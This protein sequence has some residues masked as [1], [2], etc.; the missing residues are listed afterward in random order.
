MFAMIMIDMIAYFTDNYIGLITRTAS[1]STKSC[2]YSVKP[3]IK[4]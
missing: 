2:I 4:K 3:F 1:V